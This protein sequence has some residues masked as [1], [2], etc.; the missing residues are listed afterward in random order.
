MT[1]VKGYKIGDAFINL[2]DHSREEIQMINIEIQNAEEVVL[3]YTENTTIKNGHLSGRTAEQLNKMP[4]I[5]NRFSIDRNILIASMEVI[6]KECKS[7]EWCEQCPLSS[8]SGV[9][10]VDTEEYNPEDWDIQEIVDKE[11]R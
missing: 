4:L 1:T 9:C 6:K 10:M 5:D 2:E 7:H 3:Y 11:I 8:N